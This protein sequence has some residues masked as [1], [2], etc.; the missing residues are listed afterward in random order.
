MNLII[1]QKQSRTLLEE[2]AKSSFNY[3]MI[4]RNELLIA[5]AFLLIGIFISSLNEGNRFVG[6]PFMAVG[7]LEIIK[8]PSRENRW[9]KKKEKD[10]IFNKNIE[11]EITNDSLKIRYDKE[12]KVHKFRDMR[13][14]LVSETGMLFKVTLMEY[15]YISF[16]A[17]GTNKEREALI[18]NLSDGFERGKI[19]IKRM[20]NKV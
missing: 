15:Y 7:M 1:K 5:I 9:V 3:T 16:K 17:L 2:H 18:N 4:G 19:K 14:C 8:Y 11:F 6:L 20:H 12:E 13:K 10:T